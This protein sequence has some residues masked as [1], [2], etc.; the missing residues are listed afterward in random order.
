MGNNAK[1]NNGN[2]AK[3]KANVGAPPT[4]RR[5][6]GTGAL[7]NLTANFSKLGNMKMNISKGAPRPKMESFNLF[8]NSNTVTNDTVKGLLNKI[9]SNQSRFNG[10]NKQI[11]RN[12]L[13]KIIRRNNQ[14]Q[15]LNSVARNLKAKMFANNVRQLR[16]R[17]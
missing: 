6:Q 4:K 1:A 8:L 9:T 17:P 2:N 15:N 7:P 16:N 3:A 11:V 5:A 14:P 10:K 12:V 13:N